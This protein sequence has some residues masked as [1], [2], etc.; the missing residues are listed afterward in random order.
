MEEN[1]R[2]LSTMNSALLSTKEKL[3]SETALLFERTSYLEQRL[4][5]L[6]EVTREWINPNNLGFYDNG[7]T[8][9]KRGVTRRCPIQFFSLD[10]NDPTAP[11][12]SISVEPNV[13]RNWQDANASCKEIQAKLAEPKST[14]ELRKLTDY[15]RYNRTDQI[16]GG[17][18]TGGLNPG[19]MWLWPSL[20]TSLTNIDPSMWFNTPDIST[21]NNNGK[22][23]RLSYDRNL[24]RYALQG[25]DCQRYLYFVCEYDVNS[26][27]PTIDRLE[28]SLPN[29]KDFE[30]ATV[31]PSLHLTP[32]TPKTSWET[33]L[34]TTTLATTTTQSAPPPR[35]VPHYKRISWPASL[36]TTTRSTTT[37]QVTSPP[38]LTPNY[39]GVIGF[40]GI[41]PQLR[42]EIPL[43]LAVL[44]D[45]NS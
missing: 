1:I 15:L 40:K 18:W 29:V 36:S 38:P 7:K 14:D 37:T 45:T 22:C 9:G 20:G 32:E 42:N 27:A 5:D 3:E 26:T 11:C 39:V 31:S 8:T 30:G 24:Q 12:Y 43:N 16:G 41:P 33:P 4:S 25:S 2:S 44:E 34:S 6:E 21:E 10:E 19:L 35:P 23:L 17:Y 28:K 13:R